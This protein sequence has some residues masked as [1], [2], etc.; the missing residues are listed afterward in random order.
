MCH[1]F[2]LFKF[3]PTGYF[4]SLILL[5]SSVE[6]Y[7]SEMYQRPMKRC[8]GYEKNVILLKKDMNTFVT[9]ENIPCDG[10]KSAKKCGSVLEK[11]VLRDM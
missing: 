2:F 11:G 9:N 1:L 3:I 10:E 8:V 5:N 7:A 4:V 6:F